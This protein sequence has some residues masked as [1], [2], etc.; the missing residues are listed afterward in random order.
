MD[1]RHLR[2]FL[3]VLEDQS[4]TRAAA[5]L[6]IATA[7]L[8][9]RIARLESELGAALLIRNP[10]APTPAG[11]AFDHHAR[12]IV[13]D[14]DTAIDAVSK[15]GTPSAAVLRIGHLASGAADF[16]EPLYRALAKALPRMTVRIFELPLAGEAAL[17]SGYVDVAFLRQPVDDPDLEL[18]PLYT[19]PRVA[20]LAATHPLAAQASLTVADLADTPITAVNRY[21]NS[22]T[23]RTYSLELERNG[24]PAPVLESLTLSEAIVNV[25]IRGA[26][27]TPSAG[28]ARYLSVPGITFV[29]LVDAQP[30]GPVAACRRGD[31]RIAV[32]TFMDVAAHVAQTCQSIVTVAG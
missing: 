29:P 3:A 20:A 18:V 30:S 32:R 19:T 6:G 1:I 26:V 27:A 12:R 13:A 14:I 17:R 10:V 21:Q 28:S 11:I 22:G 2:A 9:E 15:V 24:D 7:T 5:R 23:R 25:L 31:Q 16:N 4:F 8:S